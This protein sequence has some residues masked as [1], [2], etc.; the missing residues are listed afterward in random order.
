M[1]KFYL[2]GMLAAGLA[3]NAQT[4]STGNLGNQSKI[5]SKQTGDY[6]PAS[7]VINP[8]ANS[9]IGQTGKGYG[10]NSHWVIVGQTEFDRP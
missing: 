8:Q 7:P 10:K 4:P 5:T 6:T 1:K 3:V 9:R 2:L